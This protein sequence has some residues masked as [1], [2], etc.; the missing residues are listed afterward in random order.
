MEGWQKGAPAV[1][2]FS[3]AGKQKYF[4]QFPER[5]AWFKQ[6]YPEHFG[7]SASVATSSLKKVTKA[8]VQ[9][10]RLAA[11][12]HAASKR[13]QLKVSS[14]AV[15]AMGVRRREGGEGLGGGLETN[16]DIISHVRGGG[17]IGS[18]GLGS[19]F[20]ENGKITKTED[21]KF[22]YNGV[23]YDSQE[24]AEKAKVEKETT[25][26]M[27][28]SE[29]LDAIKSRTGIDLDPD[30][31]GVSISDVMNAMGMIKKKM[32]DA[33]RGVGIPV[34]YPYPTP[35]EL[36]KEQAARDQ[37]KGA[38]RVHR[39][40]ESS[41]V[42]ST[43][44]DPE[45]WFDPMVGYNRNTNSAAV[46]KQM[47]LGKGYFP[48]KD[49][50]VLDQK[51][52]DEKKKTYK[53]MYYEEKDLVKTAKEF[54][55]KIMEEKKLQECM[56]MTMMIKSKPEDESMQ[57]GDTSSEAKEEPGEYDYEGD[58]AKSQLRSIGY[59]AKMLHD[60]LEDNTN[61]PEWVQSKIT[62]AEDYIL[63][64]ANY[65]RGEMMNEEVEQVDEESKNLRFDPEAPLRMSASIVKMWKK[66][67][68]G[69]KKAAAAWA[70]H[71]RRIQKVEPE[72]MSK[73][74]IEDHMQSHF[75]ES[76]EIAEAAAQTD[77]LV[78]R[79]MLP[80]QSVIRPGAGFGDDIK[81]EKIKQK[82]TKAIEKKRNVLPTDNPSENEL[83]PQSMLPDVPGYPP[84]YIVPEPVPTAPVAKESK[85]T[86]KEE[87]ANPYVNAASRFLTR[88][89]SRLVYGE[90]ND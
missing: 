38:L 56:P 34:A 36:A 82:I 1:L 40:T 41:M 68:T 65:M 39:G 16:R 90:K 46:E 59:N 31:D 74:D 10:Q 15:Q 12:R 85:P 53:G 11:I 5:E 55:E 72:G 62:L 60:M 17:T 45:S 69:D 9:K 47:E 32:G 75:G 24:D 83:V 70:K 81:R 33:A 3:S 25:E 86:M 49:Q 8:K 80:D 23:V 20:E 44:T 2:K 26:N 19:L 42:K 64:A 54:A 21:G 79:S 4:K 76:V 61:L 77:D 84:G 89:S 30:K 13:D 51:N 18:G 50:Q 78:P 57:K 66:S 88:T 71:V 63:T 87:T 35:E 48:G 58:M 27:T 7:K 73:K 67:K 22:E 14:A 28:S 29:N 6:N 52:D 43:M 37:K